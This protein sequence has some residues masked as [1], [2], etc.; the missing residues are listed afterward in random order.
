[1]IHHNILPAWRAVAEGLD[2]EVVR[3][4]L[5]AY[6][7]GR[8]TDLQFSPRTPPDVL[9]T[10]EG[11]VLHLRFDADW[12]CDIHGRKTGATFRTAVVYLH[13]TPD[14]WSL[15]KVEPLQP[16]ADHRPA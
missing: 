8:W 1:M 16:P 5:E 10:E 13:G 3:P 6:D 11:A 2:P 14:A 15:A 4:L 12:L 9:P 7:Q